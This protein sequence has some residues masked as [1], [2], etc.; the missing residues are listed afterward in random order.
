MN[1]VLNNAVIKATKETFK[2]VI[3]CPIQNDSPAEM[4]MNGGQV[5]TSVIISFV[6]GV[7]GAFTMRCSKEFGAKMASQMLGIEIGV[8]S[9]DMKDAI[10]EMFNMIVGATKTYYATDGDPFKISVPTTVIGEDYR[11]HIKAGSDTKVS[12]IS[13]KCGTDEMS[14]EV[15]LS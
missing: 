7:S 13:F 2:A 14:I 8:D 15:F 1:D 11:V 9:D 5:D 6:G 3:G 4:K 12:L 10:G